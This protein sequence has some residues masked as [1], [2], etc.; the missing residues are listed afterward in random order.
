[1]QNDKQTHAENMAWMAL[2]KLALE[3]NAAIVAQA[4]I[5][6]GNIKA[7]EDAKEFIKWLDN[8]RSD[9]E[10]NI[11][12]TIKAIEEEAIKEAKK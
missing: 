7:Q 2:L 11:Q 10:K 12:R 8:L 9:Y 1:M 3:Y 5:S 6:V 4:T